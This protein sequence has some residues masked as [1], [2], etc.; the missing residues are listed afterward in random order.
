MPKLTLASLPSSGLVDTP[1]DAKYYDWHL[2]D[3]KDKPFA[4]FK[5][6]YRSWDSLASLQLIPTGHP[7]ALLCPTPS[8]LSLN[9]QWLKLK[10]TE[11]EVVHCAET[12]SGGQ[13]DTIRSGAPRTFDVE[14]G[15]KQYLNTRTRD[16][17][18]FNRDTTPW[19]TQVNNDSDSSGNLDRREALQVPRSPSPYCPTLSPDALQALGFTV[20]PVPPLPSPTQLKWGDILNRP[21]PKI[22]QQHSASGYSRSPPPASSTPSLMPSILKRLDQDPMSQSPSLGVATTLRSLRPSQAADLI[23]EKQIFN[24]DHYLRESTEV[25]APLVVSSRRQSTAIPAVGGILSNNSLR[26]HQTSSASKSRPQLKMY[27]TS[28]TDGQ[29]ANEREVREREPY[30]DFDDTTPLSLTE[31]EWMCH[32]PSSTTEKAKRR[33]LGK[34]GGLE[35]HAHSGAMEETGSSRKKTINWRDTAGE[36]SAEQDET[37]NLTDYGNVGIPGGWV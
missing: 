14:D 23:K 36:K 31:A 18:P 16:S 25:P 22:P 3:P 33:Q 6:H 10:S 4:T 20:P 1:Q 35:M 11:E 27:P 5:F 24:T 19:S 34:M 2:M 13:D 37:D 8:L 30:A 26:K 12:E 17:S 32:T 7:R 21:L 29:D 28:N 15:Y 9:G